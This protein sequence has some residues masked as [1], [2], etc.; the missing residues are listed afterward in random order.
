M[1]NRQASI[2]QAKKNGRRDPLFEFGTNPCCEIILRPTQFC[3]LTEVVVRANDTRSTLKRK[4]ELATLLGTIQSTLTHFPYLRKSWTRNTTE[5]RLLGVSLTG[6][7]DNHLLN[8]ADNKELPELL[9]NLRIHAIETNRYWADKF[10][11][12]Q[13]AAITCVKPSGTVSQLVDSASGIHPRHSRF[14]YRRVRGDYKDPLTQFMIDAGV[15]SE[16]DVMKPHSTAVF[17]FPKKAPEKALLRDELSAIQHLNLWL[18]YQKHWCEHK[19]SITISVKEEDWPEV[20]AWVW[21]HF[22]ELSGVSFLPY[23]GGNYRQAPYEEVDEADYNE[24]LEKMPK[25]ID[26]DALSEDEDNAEGSQILACTAGC[27]L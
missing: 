18:V 25:E 11:I 26:W 20:G 8:D 6:I 9:D 5:E 12:P 14:Y 19:P 21:N 13:S 10:C 24:L 16:P 4:V 22:D 2:L 7:L 27:E 15:P 1:F 3:N 23:D 17:T